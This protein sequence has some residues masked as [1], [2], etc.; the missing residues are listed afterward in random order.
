MYVHCTYYIL[1]CHMYVHI[2]QAMRY[3]T[4]T[5]CNCNYAYNM[6]VKCVY[7]YNRIQT[8]I[9]YVQ[10]T[11]YTVLGYIH[12]TMVHVHVHTCMHILITA[13]VHVHVRT[14]TNAVT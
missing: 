3:T 7:V 11:M 4:A 10:C 2:Q 9:M 5:T 8:T 13:H 1:Q 14:C 12:C 6:Q